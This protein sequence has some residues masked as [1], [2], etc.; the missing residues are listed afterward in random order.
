MNK[1]EIIFY[2]APDGTTNLDVRLEEETVWL[3]QYQMAE[4]FNT[5]RTSVL[6]HIKNIYAT[7]ELEENSTCA[8][9][10][11]V[12]IEGKRNIIR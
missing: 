4:L 12:Q 3:D 11:Q 9:I 8:K 6:R 7:E 10:A 2:Q 1:G 5:N